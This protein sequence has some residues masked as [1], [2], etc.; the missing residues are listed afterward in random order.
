MS[1]LSVITCSKADSKLMRKME[2]GERKGEERLLPHKGSS[3]FSYF[4]SFF[5]PLFSLSF[6]SFLNLGQNVLV[7]WR[8][9]S[10]NFLVGISYIFGQSRRIV[11]SILL[12]VRSTLISHV[13]W[14]TPLQL[15]WFWSQIGWISTAFVEISVCKL[16][17]SRK[18]MKAQ[19]FLVFSGKLK[20]LCFRQSTFNS[21][22]KFF[23]IK[24]PFFILSLFILLLIILVLSRTNLLYQKAWY[25]LHKQINLLHLQWVASLSS[26]GAPG[27][28]IVSVLLENT[29]KEIREIEGGKRKEGWNRDE[30]FQIRGALF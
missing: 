10:G 30:F 28:R 3:L 16:P 26:N 15:S 4:F 12:C 1:E 13:S 21:W 25:S 22:K 27:D 2:G 19:L 17:I 11:F 29:L 20:S 23:L 6:I 8:H 18:F 14:F 24:T 9:F 5:V 7:K